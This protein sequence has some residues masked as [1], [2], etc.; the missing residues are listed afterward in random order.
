M[1][2]QKADNFKG[3]MDVLP[4]INAE[5]QGLYSLNEI[6]GKGSLLYVIFPNAEKL[7]STPWWAKFIEFYAMKSPMTALLQNLNLSLFNKQF[8]EQPIL[9]ALLNI[10]KGAGQGR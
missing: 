2:A 9:P 10:G 6:T 3:L 4:Q 5:L 8:W 7:L 1:A